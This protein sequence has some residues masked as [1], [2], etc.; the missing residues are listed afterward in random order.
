MKIKKYKSEDEMQ[1]DINKLL[2]EMNCRLVRIMNVNEI[3]SCS[4]SV[5][6]SEKKED[7]TRSVDS[8]LSIIY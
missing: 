1:E 3:D 8:K 7:G 5:N 4:I 6:I 2:S